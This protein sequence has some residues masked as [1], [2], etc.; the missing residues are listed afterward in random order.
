[1]KRLVFLGWMVLLL[2]ACVAGTGAAEAPSASPAPAVE[3]WPAVSPHKLPRWRG[4]NLLEKFQLGRG[5]QPFLEDDFRMISQLGFNFVRLPMDYRL[6]IKNHDWQQFDEAA[7]AQID[8][9]VEWGRKYH[10]HVCLNFHRAPGY[11]VAKPAEKTDLWKDA[12]AQRVCG[13]H[14]AT[15]A[16]RYKGIPSQ[17]LSFNLMN[18][19]GQVSPHVYAAVVRG[20]VAAIGREDPQRLV[21][22]DG[23]QWGNVP[24]LELADLHIAQATRGY[25]PMSIS[26]YQAT[27]VH[28]ENFPPPCWPRPLG[29]AGTLLGPHKQEGSYP[30]LID[31]PFAAATQLRLHVLTVSASALLRVAAD[32]Q[33]ILD[34]SFKCG[35]GEGE[36][37]KA[38]FQPRFH[39]YQNLY[40]RDYTATIPAGTRQVS[41]RVVDGDW[42]QLGEIGLRAGS[43]ARGAQGAGSPER[44]LSLGNEFGKKPD[45]LHYSAAASSPGF[46][47]LPG[48]DRKWLWK[49]CIVPWKQAEQQGIGVI[50]GEWGSFNRTPHDVVLAWAED[51]LAN[52]REAGWGWAM[53]NFRGPFGILDSQRAD[54]KYEDFQGHKLDRKLLDLLLR[55]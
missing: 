34:K 40:D 52:W 21:I 51:C 4:F 32:G 8:Q 18:E 31:G 1:M 15:F 23:V 46:V 2:A 37:K 13:L 27:W 12:E 33:T 55:Y 53:W 19:P 20:L 36:W 38:E 44:C 30:L 35:P 49:Q 14:W 17:R 10:I 9:A 41:I 28:G 7:L 25:Q 24:V 39:V 5:Q 11:T 22:A 54:V 16:R 29:P 42:A 47:G 43:E 6:W 45:L 48:Q 50:V 26:H 3:G